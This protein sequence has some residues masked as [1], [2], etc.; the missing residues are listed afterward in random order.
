MGAER[1]NAAKRN[2]KEAG[3]IGVDEKRRKR[4]ERRASR[5]KKWDGKGTSEK[6][7]RDGPAVIISDNHPEK[8][9]G[10]S[11]LSPSPHRVVG[12]PSGYE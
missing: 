10:T 1:D 8:L 12:P 7:R 4:E 5:N 3:G 9:R 2:T 6:T 11:V